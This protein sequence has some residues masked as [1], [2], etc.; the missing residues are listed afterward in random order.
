MTNR[1]RRIPR[2]LLILLLAPPVALGQQTAPPARLPDAPSS[3]QP[4]DR[5]GR[6]ELLARP[7][8]FFPDLATTVGPLSPFQK[9]KLFVGN[10]VSGHGILGSAAGAGIGQARDELQGYG[11]GAAGYG[12][13]F[14]SSLARGASSQFFG[15]FVLASLL[16]QD[17]RFFVPVRQGLGK[18]IK[19]AARRLLISS[20]DAGDEAVDWPGLMGPLA[21]EGLANVYLPDSDTSAS[22]TFRRY[23]ADQGFRFGGNLLRV[24]WPFIFSKLRM[25]KPG[26]TD[27]AK[28]QH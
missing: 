26:G 11:Q 23:G 5:L 4:A 8:I 22:H 9:F 27:P 14:G 19:Y 17:P 7:S 6:F 1:A 24:Y 28:T 18:N 13:R 2:I 12:K 21:A 10:S 3:V 16:H 15:T 20:T 25:S